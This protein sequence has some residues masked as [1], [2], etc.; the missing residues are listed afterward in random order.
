[1]ELKDKILEAF[2]GKVVRKDLANKVKGN[3]P[4]PTYVLEYLLGQYCACDDEKAIEEGLEKV[5]A[6]VSNNYVNRAQAEEIKAKIKERGRYTVIDKISVVLNDK[7]D[8]FEASFAN[9]GIGRIPINDSVVKNNEKLLSDNGVWSIVVVNYLTGDDVRLRWEIQSLKPI[10]ISNLDIDDYIAQREK[11]TTDE[12][13][14]LLMHTVGLNPEDMNRREKLIVLS[15]LLPHIENNYN[16]M[17]LGPKGTGKSHVY[18][19]FSPYSVLV[20]GGDVTSARLFVKM[21]G[22]REILGLVGLWD[23]VAWDEYEQKKNRSIDAKLVD[24]MQNYLANKSFNRGKGTYEAIASMSFVGNTKHT[25]PYM[26]KKIG[27]AHV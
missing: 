13:I 16:F 9:L 24:I 25:V 20:S 12:W 18:Q 26:L 10:Q 19:E 14:D 7:Q 17:E 27:R 22:N 11:F 8:V 2:N 5:K 3:L 23:V 4:V 6:I 21:S 1:M 15:R